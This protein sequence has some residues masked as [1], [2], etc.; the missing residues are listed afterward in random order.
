MIPEPTTHGLMCNALCYMLL[1]RRF[2]F[3]LVL[4]L[5]AF[6]FFEVIPAVGW[7]RQEED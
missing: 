2:L 5:N 4:L 1:F 7:L 6:H 3:L